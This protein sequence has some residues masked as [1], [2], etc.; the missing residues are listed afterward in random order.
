MR[1]LTRLV[2]AHSKKIENHIHAIS[3]HYMYYNF[4]RY[5]QPVRCSP[6]MAAGVSKKLWSIEDIVALLDNPQ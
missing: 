3:L 4:A 6:A 5:H 2:N 1:R